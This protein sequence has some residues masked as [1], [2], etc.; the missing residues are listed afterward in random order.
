MNDTTFFASTLHN[1]R[2]AELHREAEIRELRA[3]RGAQDD[4][5]E[6]A[7]AAASR[8]TAGRHTRH[9]RRSAFATAR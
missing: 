1:Q 4:G 3:A 9:A 8:L 7:G 5:A 6:A 2:T